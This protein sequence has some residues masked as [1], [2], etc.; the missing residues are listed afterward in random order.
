MFCTWVAL[1]PRERTEYLPLA[2]RAHLFAGTW[3]GTYHQAEGPEG[4]PVDGSVQ[5]VFEKPDRILTGIG[6]LAFKRSD[7]TVFN[8][9]IKFH[10]G[11]L[12]NRFLKLEYENVD[13][14][15]VQFGTFVAELSPDGRRIS[16]K[17]V[18][19][20]AQSER[21]VTGTATISR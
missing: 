13:T 19:Y 17:Y 12:H 21:I 3:M 7:G 15:A 20:G 16:G 9:N 6:T 14:G 4:V 5:L 8:L 2:D 11:F 10:G 1:P 18:G